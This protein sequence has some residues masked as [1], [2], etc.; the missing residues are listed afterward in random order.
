MMATGAAPTE[1]D[2]MAAS[3]AAL[4]DGATAEFVGWGSCVTGVDRWQRQFSEAQ[5]QP[6]TSA[7]HLPALMGSPRVSKSASRTVK[8][9]PAAYMRAKPRLRIGRCQAAGPMICNEDQHEA[10]SEDCRG[11]FGCRLPDVLERRATRARDPGRQ[12][13]ARVCAER[14]HGQ[15]RQTLRFQ[16]QDVDRVVL[17]DLGQAL[18]EAVGCPRR[19]TAA[20][21]EAELLRSEE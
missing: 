1:A 15:G 16:G 5:Q 9:F 13:C 2:T 17:G 6:G 19:P 21:R 14:H 7:R 3:W 12:A 10:N 18:A 20:V 11:S 4:V 8:A